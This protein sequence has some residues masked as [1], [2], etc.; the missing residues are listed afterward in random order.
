[1]AQEDEFREYASP[2]CFQHEL[3]G[4][5]AMISVDVAARLNELLEGERA[6]TMGVLDMNTEPV[7]K[8][9]TLA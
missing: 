5:A 2:P 7:S 8:I 1:M 6:G 9:R 3:E 4:P